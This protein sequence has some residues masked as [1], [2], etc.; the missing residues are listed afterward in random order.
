VK[1]VF[2][3][4]I[5]V[6]YL[7]ISPLARGVFKGAYVLVER[8]SGYAWAHLMRTNNAN[9][10]VKAVCRVRTCLLKHQFQLKVVRT[11]AGKVEASLEAAMKL[12]ELHTDVNAAL[13]S[14]GC[15]WYCYHPR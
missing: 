9:W 8:V 5:S 15:A 2:G 3:E 11:D 13:S 1:P 10:F 14:D 7:P 4:E 12:A 6:D